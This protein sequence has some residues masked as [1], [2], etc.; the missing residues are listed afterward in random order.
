MPY[1][2]GDDAEDFRPKIWLNNGVFQLESP[3]KFIAFHVRLHFFLFF[4][5]TEKIIHAYIYFWQ[6][7]NENMEMECVIEFPHT[8]MDHRPRKRPHLGWDIAPQALKEGA[9][10][11]DIERLP[12]YKF[13]RI[14][15][16]EKQNGE[17]QESFGGI[18]TE[19]DTDSPIEHVLSPEN[20]ECCICL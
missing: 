4:Y 20:V 15:D 12:K 19:C 14:G 13:Q 6:K 3:F 1:I 16:F 18:I 10:K 9:T 8:H 7:Q 5:F 2:W 17:I 11:E